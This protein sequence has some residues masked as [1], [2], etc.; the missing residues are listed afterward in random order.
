MLAL[1]REGELCICE[2]QSVL[3]Q[4]R[5]IV[6]LRLKKLRDAGIV[7]TRRR[8]QWLAYRIHTRYVDLVET[9]FE[10]F[11]DSIGWDKDV[12]DDLKSLA[13][14]LKKRVDDWCAS[15]KGKA[16]LAAAGA[17]DMN[18]AANMAISAQNTSVG[19]A[20]R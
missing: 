14:Q 10:A 19:L 4:D 16:A 15:P 7:R 3:G 13:S 8:R 2:I 1:L 5:A 11:D 20:V 12:N 9:V 17:D 6:D 18:L